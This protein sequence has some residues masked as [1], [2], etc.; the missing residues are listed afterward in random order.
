MQ[1]SLKDRTED[2]RSV[3]ISFFLITHWNMTLINELTSFAAD[4]LRKLVEP[5]RR[6]ETF[7]VLF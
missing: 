1:T 4:V 3:S 6:R 2:V 7:Y 5:G